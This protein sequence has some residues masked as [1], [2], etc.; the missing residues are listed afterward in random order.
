MVEVRRLFERINVEIIN[1]CNLKCSFCPT[2]ERSKA[3]M[4]P[5]QFENIAGRIAP[6][7]KEVVLHLLGEP[8]SHPEFSQIILAADRV[9]L[10]VNIVTNGLL[11]TGDRVQAA[12]HPIV[13]QVSVSLQSFDNNFPDGDANLYLRRVKS[14]TDK[15]LA[16]RPDLYMNLRFWDLEGLEANQTNHNQ[17]IR[18]QLA[19]VYGFDWDDVK[20][21]IKRR[22][23]YRL[24]GRLYLHFDSRFTW[25]SLDNQ[26]LQTEGYC[27]ALRGHF[28]IHADGTMVPCCLDHQGVIALGNVMTSPIEEILTTP[29]ALAIRSGFD[30]GA[31]VEEL[32]KRCGYI[33][34]FSRKGPALRK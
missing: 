30:R 12:L 17:D 27:H 31:I 34:R 7:T 3:V 21:N 25:P 16:E 8:L 1:T 6:L 29:R 4:T 14:F 22:K 33:A 11:L 23:N 15:A 10:P 18:M 19:E 13:R 28:G 5:E 2:P 9:K 24:T 26:V 32:C 20:V